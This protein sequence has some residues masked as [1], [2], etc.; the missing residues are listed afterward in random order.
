MLTN[1]WSSGISLFHIPQTYRLSSSEDKIITEFQ[2][3]CYL[4]HW[5]TFVVFGWFQSPS[6]LHLYTL[7]ET[8]VQMANLYVCIFFL[9]VSFLDGNLISESQTYLA[10]C[11]SSSNARVIGAHVIKQ[12]YYLY[13]NEVVRIQVGTSM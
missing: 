13:A 8:F 5:A 11:L 6:A 3:T 7:G 4:Q 1:S 9:L 12:R 2:L 10:L